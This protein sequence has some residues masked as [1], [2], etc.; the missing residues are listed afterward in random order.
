MHLEPEGLA[1]KRFKQ[2]LI[3]AVG[4]EEVVDME[5]QRRNINKITESELKQIIEQ[6]KPAKK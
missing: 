5:Q 6:Y 1:Y 3:D 4:E 2:F